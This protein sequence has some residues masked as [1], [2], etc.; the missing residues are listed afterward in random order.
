MVKMKKYQQIFIQNL[1]KYRKQNNLSQAELSELCGVA[2]GTIGN[3][4]CGLSKPSFDLLLTMSGVLKISPALLFSEDKIALSA[5]KN[6][7][8]TKQLLQ[9]I[10]NKINL[11]FDENIGD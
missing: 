10:R 6:P 2:T 3:I 7:T 9:T 5:D 8:E 1:K 4:E 11:L